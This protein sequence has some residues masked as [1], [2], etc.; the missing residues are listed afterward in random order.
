MNK[1]NISS[2]K[3]NYY[4]LKYGISKWQFGKQNAYLVIFAGMV[5]NDIFTLLKSFIFAND[6]CLHKY[7]FELDE[8]F[9]L[10]YLTQEE[11]ENFKFFNFKLNQEEYYLKYI[12]PVLNSSNYLKFLQSALLYYLNYSIQNNTL[13]TFIDL[14]SA[15]LYVNPPYSKKLYKNIKN[16]TIFSDF[17]L[18]CL[19]G[20]FLYFTDSDI[21]FLLVFENTQEFLKTKQDHVIFRFIHFFHFIFHQNVVQFVLKIV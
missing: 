21:S 4:C 13:S 6:L 11:I 15:I 3:I 1:K 20:I 9:N 17:S 2:L 14:F 19:N 10:L 16:L 12:L 18:E 5:Y 7:T 8:E